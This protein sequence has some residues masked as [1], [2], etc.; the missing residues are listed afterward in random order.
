[1]VNSY[2]VDSS[3]TNKP[4][5]R[6]P[7]TRKPSTSKPLMVAVALLLLL[8]FAAAVQPASANGWSYRKLITID[9]SK[10]Q[11]TVT[12]FPVLIY[13]SGGDYAGLDNAQS[14][15]GDIVF[16]NK[17]NSVRYD[18]EIEY[19]S[20][21]DDK[22]V[23]WVEIDSLSSG[24]N[25][26]IYMW[27]GNSACADQW[28]IAA[29]WDE[30]GSNNYKGVWHLLGDGTTALPDATSNSN[31]GTKQAAGPAN[32]TSGQIDGAQVFAGVANDYVNC[33]K[34]PSL[35]IIDV[36][37]IEAWVKINNLTTVGG[38]VSKREGAPANGFDFKWRGDS[39]NRINFYTGNGANTD[40]M[41]SDNNVITD[42]NWHHVAVTRDNSKNT[43]LYVDG[44]NV[45]SGV[46][47]FSMVPLISTH[48]EIARFSTAYFNGTMDEVRI[49]ASA[50]SGDW[51]KTSYDNQ[52]SP[53]VGGFLEGV[54]DQSDAPAGTDPVPDPSA[55][56]LFAAGLVVL[57]GYVYVGRRRNR[58]S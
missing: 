47:T 6:K 48:L 57:A 55:L 30:G 24:S 32:T 49:S 45:G 16:T 4:S 19:F 41:W 52:H 1:M 2:L 7:S 10:V 35:N 12:N 40:N 44:Q 42:T 5:T 39:G 43:I 36:I 50:R 25:K 14:D 15:G 56:V 23:A 27:Y 29:T 21:A 17:A 37:T 8:F 31:T 18:H 28:H 9:G 33:G 11:G 53:G 34:N 3:L 26:T 38:F 20:Q 54:G 13:L 46:A 58:K 22:L 51:I